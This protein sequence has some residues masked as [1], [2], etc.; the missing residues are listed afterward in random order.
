M[1]VGKQA[2]ANGT[3]G[4]CRTAASGNR[5]R[6]AEQRAWRAWMIFLNFGKAQAGNEFTSYKSY[7]MVNQL[8]NPT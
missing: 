5:G 3:G 8:E 4:K 2:G 1:L 6:G 7:Q